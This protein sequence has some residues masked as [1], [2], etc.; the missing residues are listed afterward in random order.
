MRAQDYGI[1]A[2]GEWYG[3]AAIN[4]VSAGEPLGLRESTIR[5]KS[6]FLHIRRK[7][8]TQETSDLA[9]LAVRDLVVRTQL[10]LSTVQVL[11]VVTQNPDA[12]GLPHTSAVLQAK[13]DLPAV[14]AFDISLGCS[15]FVY[16]L[17]VITAF[18]AAH[19][20]ERGLLITAD[21]YSKIIDTEDRKTA[22]L[23]G[24]GATAT[25]VSN[26]PKLRVGSFDFGTN[27][28]YHSALEVGED[29]KLSMSGRQIYQL[30]IEHAPESVRRVLERSELSP[31]DVDQFILHQGSL[32][33]LNAINNRLVGKGSI[34]GR[35]EAEAIF[36]LAEIG[37]T[38][39]SSI[40]MSLNRALRD[41]DKVIAIAGFGVGFSWASGVLHR[42]TAGPLP[43]LVGQAPVGAKHEPTEVV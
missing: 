13:L 34:G 15:G 26:S 1:E 42:V 36:T 22:L 6:G 9:A 21:P 2:I 17:S 4:C 11:I 39:S 43:Q 32:Y 19:N 10:D 29:G 33:V 20:L 27:G 31:R 40:P 38:V 3:E 16:G 28:H 35:K 7:K 12:Q 41:T 14:P 18:L 24:D 8:P 37:N 5:G 30:S 25:L 23:F